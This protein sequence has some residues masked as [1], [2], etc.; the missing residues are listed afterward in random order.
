MLIIGITYTFCFLT[1]KYEYQDVFNSRT[2]VIF[3]TSHAAVSNTTAS[4]EKIAEFG[5]SP[6]EVGTPAIDL[7][8]KTFPEN[9][10]TMIAIAKAESNFKPDAVN[11]NSDGSKDCGIFQINSVHGYDCEWLK[12]PENNMVAAR[13]VYDKQGLNAWMTYVYAKKHNLPI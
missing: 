7:I 6:Q 11:V 1:I 9:A 3:N 4:Q 8:K 13:K 10:E 12:V 5:V 2:I